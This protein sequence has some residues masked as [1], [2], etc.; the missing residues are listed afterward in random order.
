[1]EYWV[2]VSGNSYNGGIVRIHKGQC[3]EVVDER[4]GPFRTLREATSAARHLVQRFVRN[5]DRVSC[6]HGVKKERRRC[7]CPDCD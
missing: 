6:L 5:C 3:N 1:M 2:N 4:H 7:H